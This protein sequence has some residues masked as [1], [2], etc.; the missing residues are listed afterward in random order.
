MREVVLA[1][2]SAGKLRELGPMLRA[3]GFEPR[4]LGDV[5]V[6]PT[7]AEDGIEVFRCV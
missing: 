2:R 5:G 4:L 1:T 6:E 3:A 7:A